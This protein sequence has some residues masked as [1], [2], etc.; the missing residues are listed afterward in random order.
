MTH[1]YEF[2]RLLRFARNDGTRNDGTRNDGI[3]N[4]GTRNDGFCHC[5][6]ARPWQ[7]GDCYASLAMT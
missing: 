1:C 5:E 7:S 6:A 2:W 3:G 4:D